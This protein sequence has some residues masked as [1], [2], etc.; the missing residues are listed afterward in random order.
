M[1]TPT[2][3]KLKTLVTLLNR[4]INR[5]I[6]EINRGGCGVFAQ[7]VYPKLVELGYKPKIMVFDREPDEFVDYIK[8]NLKKTINNQ[9]TDSGFNLESTSFAH[10][11]LLIDN[12]AFDGLQKETDLLFNWTRLYNVFYYNYEELSVS[13]KFGGWC[14]IYDRDNSNPIMKRIIDEAFEKTFIKH[15]L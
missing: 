5:E 4:K 3:Y 14:S 13:L 10:C 12:F 2:D 15:S 6:P 11:C 1:E 8:S 9:E 7:M